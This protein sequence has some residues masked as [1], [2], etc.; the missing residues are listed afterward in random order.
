MDIRPIHTEADY[1]AA[2]KEVSALMAADPDPGTLQGD[3][4]NILATLVQAYEAKHAPIAAPDPIEVI[5]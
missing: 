5:R 1:Q 2:L 3:R 4:L